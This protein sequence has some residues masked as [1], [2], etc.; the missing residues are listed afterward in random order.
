MVPPAKL[1]PLETKDDLVQLELL[2]LLDQ[3]VEMVPLEPLEEMAKLEQLDKLE[4]LELMAAQEPLVP[5]A[6][7][8]LLACKDR[9]VLMDK[10]AQLV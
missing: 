7:Q 3:P 9:K 1:V 8:V 6:D 2:E 10:P 4:P 5:A